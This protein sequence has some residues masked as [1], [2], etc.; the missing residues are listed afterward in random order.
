LFLI[1]SLTIAGY[2]QTPQPSQ[3][4]IVVIKT[5]DIPFYVPAVKGL[6]AGLKSQG[7]GTRERIDLRVVS[8]TGKSDTDTAL[9]AAQVSSKPNLIVT[10]GTDA[11]RL[12]ADQSPS[13]PVLFC[14]VLDAVRLGIVK[15]NDSPGGT[16]SGV[17]I[18]VSP[19][20]QMDALLQAAPKVRKIGIL[21]TDRDA[22]SLAFLSDAQLDAARLQIELIPVAVAPA[23]SAR[24]ALAKF[25][26]PPDAV[27][28]I[29][30]PASSGPQALK[31]TM[32]YARVRR[33]P[34]LG[35]SS[36]TVH[37]GALVALSANL[38]DQGS[39][40]AEMAARILDGTERTIHMRVRGPRRTVLT[41][42]L[43][44]AQRLG[45]TIPKEVLHLADEVI[46]TDQED[47]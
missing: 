23:Q 37:S 22:T 36:G 44:T 35:T 4:R 17:T 40:V 6:I 47:K 18:P 11:T 32:E 5:R 21:Y 20:K 43:M 39:T 19:G 27:W 28:L 34:I 14:M 7:Y 42:N 25:P 33:I 26:S 15:S 29:P 24:D 13:T 41:L 1:L 10:L 30:D 31:D 38:E 9:V 8:L 12:T 45:I 16:F 46:E 2:A 3:I